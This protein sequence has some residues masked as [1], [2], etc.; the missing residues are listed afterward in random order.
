MSTKTNARLIATLAIVLAPWFL[1]LPA[2]AIDDES[3]CS[4]VTINPIP[5]PCPPYRVITVGALA[6]FDIGF[7]DSNSHNYALAARKLLTTT[8]T[9]PATVPAIVVVD[10]TTL[11][12]VAR[13]GFGNTS[14]AGPY[15][16]PL[17]G[18][19]PATTPRPPLPPPARTA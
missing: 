9:G 5:P 4:S 12:V 15:Y 17:A 6:S 19:C 10:T 2:S 11:T 1:A 16:T 8:L 3:L 13:L 7:V 18:N 14:T